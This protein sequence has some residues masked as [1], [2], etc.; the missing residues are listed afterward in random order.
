MSHTFRLILYLLTCF[1]SSGLILLMNSECT[2]PVNIG[3]P[4]EGTILSWAKLVIE[5]VDE[6]LV[7]LSGGDA[8]ILE[9]REQ[10]K[11]VFKSMPEDDPPRRRADTTKAQEILG[12]SPRWT[13][14]EGLK[15]TIRSFVDSEHVDID[16]AGALRQRQRK[17]DAK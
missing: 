11:L 2:D 3:S 4:Y 10:S 9:K 16:L 15:E 5:T 8:S 7:E 6:V 1:G 17:T 14:K 13:V 12:W